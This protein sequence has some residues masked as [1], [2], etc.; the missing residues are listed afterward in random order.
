MHFPLAPRSIT[1]V[2]MLTD[3]QINQDNSLSGQI[4]KT[5]YLFTYP[6]T[7]LPILFIYFS[8]SFSVFYA[9]LKNSVQLI[10]EY[11]KFGSST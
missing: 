4:R 3:I 11:P 2:G 6:S 1:L 5:D 7:W 10:R 9:S 8:S